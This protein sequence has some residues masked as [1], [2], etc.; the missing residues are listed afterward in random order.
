MN[1][2]LTSW[3]IPS[4]WPQIQALDMHTAGEPL[5]IIT[6]G[7]PEPEGTSMIDKRLYC[8]SHYEKWRKAV[9]FE[10][11]GHADMYG[12]LLTAPQRADSAFGVLFMHNEGYSTMC[13]H[14]VIALTELVRVQNPEVV[15]EQ[16]LKMDTPAGQIC[17]FY[18]ANDKQVGFYNVPSFACQ[19][20]VPV[21]LAGGHTLYCDIAFGGAYYA[22]VDADQL[23]LALTIQNS[24]E[25]ICLGRKIK[26]ALTD[27]IELEHPEDASLSF[28]Y[29]VVFYSDSQVSGSHCHSRHVCIFADGSLDRSPTGTGVSGRAALL[30]ARGELARD[31]VIHIEG[32]LAC[33][34]DVSIDALCQYDGQ[35]AVRVKVTGEAYVTAEHTFWLDPEDPIQQGFILR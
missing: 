23:D 33:G 15:G 17:A 26:H 7:L 16:Q 1:R 18:S 21:T 6:K 11:R 10:P 5:R 19:Q 3:R 32:I 14:A 20:Q 27:R 24:E 22:Y 8:L 34:F 9:M 31:E 2:Y 12:A 29:G 28:L 4:H 25:I 30:A 35:D 13:G